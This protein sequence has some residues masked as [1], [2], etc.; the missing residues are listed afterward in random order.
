MYGKTT[1]VL[2]GNTFVVSDLGGNIDASPTDTHGL[3]QW[4]TRFLSRWKLTVDGS[5]PNVLSTDDLHY[6]SVQYFLV[7]GTGTV[8]VDAPYSIIRKR[9]VG[10]GFHEDL[11]ILNHKPE[12][13]DLDIRIDAAA[14]FADLFEI[15]DALAKKGEH[16]ARIEAG[17]LVLGYRRGEYL[18]ETWISASA[19]V[20][21]DEQGIHATVHLKP[22]GEWR[23]CL[24]VVAAVD[25]FEVIHETGR[26][27]HGQDEP[28]PDMEV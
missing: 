13:L 9:A 22:H 18:R 6:F 25:G 21:F 14:D 26:H 15:K 1:S 20:E 11:E 24:D 28:R 5:V 8:Y 27:G 17:R 19:P 23:S 7:P 3:F 16:F 2:E 12:P 10:N 4:D